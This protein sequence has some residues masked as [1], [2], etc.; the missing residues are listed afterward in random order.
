[1]S[2]QIWLKKVDK[3]SI[4]N[5]I[6]NEKWVEG[7]IRNIAGEIDDTLN[8]L[9]QDIYVDLLS[10]DEDKIVRMYNDNQLKFFVTRMVMNNIR[11]KNSP[12]YMTYKKNKNKEDNI[13]DYANKI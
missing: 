10:K 4:I 11:S 6:A 2:N 13:D 7:V 9:A 1:M 3:Q 12:Y 5:I 8:D